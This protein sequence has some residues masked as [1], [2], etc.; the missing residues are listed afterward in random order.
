MG[1]SFGQQKREFF[2]LS[3]RFKLLMTQLIRVSGVFGESAIVSFNPIENILHGGGGEIKVTLRQIQS[4]TTE[5]SRR[6][7]DRMSQL[8]QSDQDA[9]S[10]NLRVMQEPEGVGQK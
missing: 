4:I 6:G 3:C 5:M 7:T 1:L 8:H 9:A 2:E 10:L